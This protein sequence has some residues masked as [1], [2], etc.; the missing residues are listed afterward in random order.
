MAVYVEDISAANM[1]ISTGERE[2]F[3]ALGER[4]ASMRKARNLTQ[5]QFAEALGV[6]QQTVQ[7]YEVGRRRIPVS[8]L[9]IVARLFDVSLE[10]LFGE[11]N[12]SRGKRGPTSRLEQQMEAISQLPKTQQR[13]VTQMLDTVLTQA[14]Q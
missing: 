6:S 1:T 11:G 3:V 13:F 4:M 2:F 12:R 10:E 7:A 8:A 5:V 14:K 9:P